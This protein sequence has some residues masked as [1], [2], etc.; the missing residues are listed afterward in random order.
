MQALG[1]AVLT[2]AEPLRQAAPAR[3]PVRDPFLRA[4]EQRLVGL[5]GQPGQPLG[6][7]GLHLGDRGGQQ[8]REPG[9]LQVELLHVGEQRVL[10]REEH[11]GPGVVGARQISQ[12]QVEPGGALGHVGQHAIQ[13]GQLPVHLRGVARAHR[14][15]ER[16]QVGKDV[17][18]HQAG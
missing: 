17:G 12:H 8:R 14:P 5:R 9:Q 11:F 16:A 13:P 2:G 15:G 10:V 1:L 18:E 6:A 3:P 7:G 4:A